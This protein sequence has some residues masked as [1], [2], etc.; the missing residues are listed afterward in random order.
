MKQSTFWVLV[1]ILVV[2]IIGI[3]VYTF[4]PS[5]MGPMQMATSSAPVVNSPMPSA[6]VNGMS[7][8]TDSLKTFSFMYP[9]AF[10]VSGGELGYTQAWRQGATTSGMVLAALTI[11]QTFEPQT[12]FADATFTVGVSSDP[13][14]VASCLSAGSGNPV[15]TNTTVVNGIPLTKI[16]L[17]DAGAGNYYETTSYRTVKGGQCY[18]IEY[19]IHSTNI[20]NYPA[21]A[22]IA[23]FDQARIRS[24]LDA[25]AQSFKFLQ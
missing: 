15:Q 17:G 13:G 3:S 6:S 5:M 16:I 25:M 10:S 22:H 18:A 8:F 4:G 23:S 9:S 24:V 7:T 1:I 2:L 14:A 20:A 21:S 11:P 19:T 12:N